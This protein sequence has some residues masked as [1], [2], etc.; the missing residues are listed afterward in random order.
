MKKEEKEQR[1]RE[2][3]FELDKI[4]L[5]KEVEIQKIRSEHEF[6]I[7]QMQVTNREHDVEQDENGAQ[8]D[9]HRNG[10]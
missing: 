6:K 3:A 7:A 1:E 5:E 8:G 10:S 2:G 4:K 9:N